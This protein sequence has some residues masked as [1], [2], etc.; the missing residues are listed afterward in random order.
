MGLGRQIGEQT[1]S[2]YASPRNPFT[3]YKEFVLVSAN[4]HSAAVPRIVWTKADDTMCFR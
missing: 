1:R 4:V 2:G 3:L